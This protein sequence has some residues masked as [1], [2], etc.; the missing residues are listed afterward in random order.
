MSMIAFFHKH[1]EIQERKFRA[2]N[3]MKRKERSNSLLL[4][5]QSNVRRIQTRAKHI[6]WIQCDKCE[7]YF[8]KEELSHDDLS[9]QDFCNNCMNAIKILRDV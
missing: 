2:T 4:R 8:N 1:Y 9:N 5:Q 3:A 6:D 7:E